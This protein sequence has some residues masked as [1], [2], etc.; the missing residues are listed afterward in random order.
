LKSKK[1]NSLTERGVS[2]S[3]KNPSPNKKSRTY[4][5]LSLEKVARFIGTDEV[6]KTNTMNKLMKHNNQINKNRGK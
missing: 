1:G 2:P 4:E 5:M 3:L 6:S